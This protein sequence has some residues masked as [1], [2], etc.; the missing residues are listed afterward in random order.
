MVRPTQI[1]CSTSHY[2]RISIL[3]SFVLTAA[4]PLQAQ[5]DSSLTREFE[6]LDAKERARI[7]KQEQEAALTDTRFQEVMSA[8]EGLFRQ[9][10]YD[11]A[12]LKYQEARGIRPYNVY[13]KVKIQDL[14]ALIAKRNAEEAQAQALTQPPDPLTVPAPAPPML[15]TVATSEAP[16][17]VN[18]ASSANV[19]AAVETTPSEPARAVPKAVAP[20]SVRPKPAAPRTTSASSPAPASGPSQATEAKKSGSMDG[21]QERTYVEGRAIVLERT[22]VSAGRSEVFRKVTHPWGQIVH[23]RD[24]IAIS[25]REWKE[26]FPER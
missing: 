21:S 14:Q 5:S 1:T 3:I 18:G 17:E 7:A 23:F 4:L 10:R 16:P 25:E 24:G 15:L 26:R 20:V 19:A 9:Q 11:E 2:V 12:L 8:A 13:P 22:L 6:R